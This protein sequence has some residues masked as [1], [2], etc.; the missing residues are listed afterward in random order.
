[1]RQFLRVPQRV[2]NAVM[3]MVDLAENNRPG[4]FVSLAE[5]AERQ[6]LSRGFL[7][8]IALPLRTAKLL[9]AK[10]GASGGYRLTRSADEISVADIVAAI[11]GPMALVECLG[12]GGCAASP[13][14]VSMKVWRTVQ[15][16]IEDALA[17][18]SL[19]DIMAGK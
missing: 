5:V 4:V 2:H 9:S 8:E 1:M 16:H 10:R 19:A 13:S 7:E 3:L 18:I 14:C 17:A 15:G 6:G 12:N 11:E